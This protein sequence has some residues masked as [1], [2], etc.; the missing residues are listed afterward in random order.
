MYRLWR[1]NFSAFLRD[2]GPAPPNTILKRIDL[3][4][5]FEPANC[6]WQLAAEANAKEKTS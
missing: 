2:V 3:D 5:D 4:G 1:D 6:S